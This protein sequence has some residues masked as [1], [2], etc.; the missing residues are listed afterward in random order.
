MCKRRLWKNTSHSTGVLSGE[1]LYLGF[2][3]TGKKKGSGNRAFLWELCEG[4]LEGGLLY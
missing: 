1:L 4:D 2:L 3:E